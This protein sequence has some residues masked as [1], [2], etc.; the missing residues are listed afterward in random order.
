[1]STKV[2]N[3]CSTQQSSLLHRQES[4]HDQASSQQSAP[5]ATGQSQAL[6]DFPPPLETERALFG[7]DF[8]VTLVDRY[9]ACVSSSMYAVQQQQRIER[10]ETVVNFAFAGMG[11][12][13]IRSLS[14]HS[15]QQRPFELNDNVVFL[16]PIHTPQSLPFDFCSDACVV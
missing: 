16:Y 15:T 10:W 4:N 3:Y 9:S 12:A 8:Q 1:M 6:F 13:Y 14:L 2:K 5:V 11:N 7:E